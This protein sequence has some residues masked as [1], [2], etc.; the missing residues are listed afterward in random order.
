MERG[1]TMSLSYHTVVDI[2][3]K[4]WKPF[5]RRSMMVKSL[6]EHNN[7]MQKEHGLEGRKWREAGVTCPKCVP[8]V[9][10]LGQ[11]GAILTSHPPKIRVRC[12][13]CKLEGYKII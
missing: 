5:E 10:M 13:E 1:I 12:P 7:L 6:E 2:L 11:V 4:Y 8:A 3:R 9:I